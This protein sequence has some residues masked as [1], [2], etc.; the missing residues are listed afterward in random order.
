MQVSITLLTLLG[1]VYQV[2]LAHIFD[3]SQHAERVVPRLLSLI[4]E[5]LVDFFFPFHILDLF[6]FC[7]VSKADFSLGDYFSSHRFQH[8]LA[9]LT[10]FCYSTSK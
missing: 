7:E 8:L 3:E 4:S 2:F 1:F 9:S 10:T 5:V 6:D